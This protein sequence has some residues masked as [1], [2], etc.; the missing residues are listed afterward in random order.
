MAGKSWGCKRTARNRSRK[1]GN[2]GCFRLKAE[3]IKP[4]KPAPNHEP[5]H[6]RT[7]DAACLPNPH[8]N[9]SY[10]NLVRRTIL[11]QIR[12]A[13]D[14]IR[15]LL[16]SPISIIAALLGL[17]RPNNPSW[18]LDQLMMAGR[19]SDRW[20]NLFELENTQPDHERKTTLDDLVGQFE[21]QL[22]TQVEKHA[23]EEGKEW[24]QGFSTYADS[25]KSS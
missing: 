23:C 24:A 6:G 11:F 12:L 8:H 1:P 4:E 7:N 21:E 15:D 10:G 2:R 20:I 18:A 14:G 25:R 13:A 19:L 3:L 17:L 5:N 16:L 22:K 9:Q